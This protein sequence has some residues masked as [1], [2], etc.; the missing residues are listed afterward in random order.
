MTT[1]RLPDPDALI[2]R[3]R[4][5]MVE[6]AHG[7]EVYPEVVY[8]DPPLAVIERGIFRVQGDAL[9]ARDESAERRVAREFEDR[10]GMQEGIRKV[11]AP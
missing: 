3:V 4:V 7:L 5:S 1:K 9:V 2:P 8:G 6:R 11:L 10:I